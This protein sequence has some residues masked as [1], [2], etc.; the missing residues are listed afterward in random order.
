MCE[1]CCVSYAHQVRVVA[2]HHHVALLAHC[3]AGWDDNG[4]FM[5]QP[6]ALANV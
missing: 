5:Y 3:V 4:S 6:R 1:L 2:R